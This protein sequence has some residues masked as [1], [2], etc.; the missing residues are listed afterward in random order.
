[1]PS[2]FCVKN[3][4]FMFSLLPGSTE[5]AQNMSN[6]CSSVKLLSNIAIRAG[7]WGFSA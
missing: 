6:V 5:L 2:V 1:V 3:L 7:F 4:R